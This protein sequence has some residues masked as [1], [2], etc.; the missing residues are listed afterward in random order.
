[1]EAAL[2]SGAEDFFAE[3]PELFEIYTAPEDLHRVKGVLE[4]EGVA[5]RAGQGRDGTHG[6]GAPGGQAGRPNGASDGGVRGPRRRPERLGQLRH[7]REDSPSFLRSSASSVST[8]G[9]GPPAGVSSTA[10]VVISPRGSAASTP[11]ATPRAH[12]HSPSSPRCSPSSWR[13]RHPTL[14]RSKRHSR[15]VSPRRDRPRRDARRDA[16]RPGSLGR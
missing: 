13:A 9:P 3:D 6:S 8:P 14:S 15:A 1:M 7:R 10:A 12:G 5:G 4:G 16:R 2:D 11:R